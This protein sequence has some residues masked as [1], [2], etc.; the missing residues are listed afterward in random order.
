MGATGIDGLTGATG[1]EGP[2]G[3]TGLEGPRGP[4]GLTGATGLD[5]AT[6]LEGSTGATGLEGATGLNGATGLDGAT[7]ATGPE[8]ATG[9]KGEA[10]M[11]LKSFMRA[12]NDVE[13]SIDLEQAVLFNKTGFAIGTINHINN[14]GN[15][16]F[17]SI[18]Y[19]LVIAKIYH[20]YSVQIAAFLNG[21]LIPGSVVGEPA[22]TSVALIHI[23]IEVTAADLLPNVLSSTGV[24]ATMQIRNHSSY[25]TPIVLDGRAG[26]GSDLTQTNASIMIIQICDEIREHNPDHQ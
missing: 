9:A 7:G 19:Y 17:G 6:G 14:T 23:I 3:A 5:G 12:Y 2:M 8:G 22:T 4:E 15:I 24:A 25:I 20:L 16:L 11:C 10:S 18:G 21:V 26:S 1:P 13:Q